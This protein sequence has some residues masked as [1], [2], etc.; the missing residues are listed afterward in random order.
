MWLYMKVKFLP[1]NAEYESTSSG[2]YN[3]MKKEED[4]ISTG[5]NQLIRPEKRKPNSLPGPGL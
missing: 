5:I 1:S 4:A 2:R 3:G